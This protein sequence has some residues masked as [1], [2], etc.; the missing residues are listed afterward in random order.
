MLSVAYNVQGIHSPQIQEPYTIQL[1]TIEVVR[2]RSTSRS[3]TQ[4]GNERVRG[5]RYEYEYRVP[6]LIA[7]SALDCA[8]CPSLTNQAVISRRSLRDARHRAVSKNKI[9]NAGRNMVDRRS[10]TTLKWQVDVSFQ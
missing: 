8:Q 9:G 4:R 1:H 2:L 10:I 5:T 3:S 7:H 6:V